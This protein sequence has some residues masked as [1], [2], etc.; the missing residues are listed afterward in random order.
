MKKIGILTF[1]CAHNYGAV[2]QCYALQEYL[3]SLGYD[4][5][6]INYRPKYLFKAYRIINRRGF[7]TSNPVR[8]IR[9]LFHELLMAP[10]RCVRRYRFNRFIRTNLILT[11]AVS[12]NAIPSDFDAY[13]VGSDQ[14]W[15]PDITRGFDNVYFCDFHFRKGDRRYLSYAA[16]AEMDSL[17]AEDA[18]FYR[19]ALVNLDSIS[20]REGGL[21]EML[22]PLSQKEIAH[23]LDPALLIDRGM[24]GKIASDNPV[25]GR[26]VLVY[27]VREDKETE[28]IAQQ[29]ADQLG[30]R[31]VSLVAK[32]DA[33]RSNACLTAAPEHFVTMIR[34]ADCVI[35][36]SFHATAFSIIF[37]RPF[38]AV[39]LND[40]KDSRVGSLLESLGLVDRL[41]EKDDKPVFSD[42]EYTEANR[43]LDILRS[44]SQ[45][46]LKSALSL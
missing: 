31:V 15:N 21:K 2:L 43:R 33:F 22:Q 25:K 5:R 36:T 37:N 40:G 44:G 41:V 23:V 8:L 30:I 20:V 10:I 39:R 18:D 3:K 13:V 29:V 11:P 27:Q 12:K 1:H 6:V 19:T 17:N 32:V 16:S 9:N 34:D 26:Y 46:Y 45:D 7:K 14:I 4:A 38:Y 28:K 24:W 35:T 42:I